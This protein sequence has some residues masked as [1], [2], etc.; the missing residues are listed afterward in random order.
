MKT[1]SSKVLAAAVRSASFELRRQTPLRVLVVAIAVGTFG[2]SGCKKSESDSGSTDSSDSTSQSSGSETAHTPTPPPTLP[3]VKPPAAVTKEPDKKPTEEQ[4]KS[5]AKSSTP[6]RQPAS[7]PAPK[8]QRFEYDHDALVE[9][10]RDAGLPIPPDLTA[11]KTDLAALIHEQVLTSCASGSAED[12]GRLGSMYLAIA[13]NREESSLAVDCYTKAKELAPK[14]HKWPYMLARLFLNRNSDVRGRLELERTI[15]LE[16]NY[17]MGYGWLGN[18]CLKQENGA[19]AKEFFTKYIDLKPEDAFGY[20]GRAAAFLNLNDLEAVK[21]DLDQAMELDPSMGWSYVLLAHY[22]EKTGEGVLA[23]QAMHKASTLPIRP[24]MLLRDPLS[25]DRW[26]SLGATETA[27]LELGRLAQMRDMPSARRLSELLLSDHSENPVLILGLSRFE[28][29][30]G[31]YED[32]LKLAMRAKE[33]DPDAPETHETIARCKLGLGETD[34]ALAAAERAVE[35]NGDADYCH[36]VKG[37]VL[38]AMGRLDDAKASFMRDRELNPGRP[39]TAQTIANIW[40]RQENYEKA[41][42]FYEKALL[43]AKVG[44]HPPKTFGPLFA[45]LGEIDLREDKLDIA[46]THFGQAIAADPGYVD[47]FMSL[48]KA[49]IEQDR[50]NEALEFCD[51]ILANRPE[52]MVYKLMRVEI[53][54]RLGKSKEALAGAAELVKFYPDSADAFLVA[55]RVLNTNK[56]FDRAEVSFKRSVDLAPGSEKARVAYVEFLLSQK[57]NKEALN[58]SEQGLEVLPKSVRLANT[59]GWFRAT[60]DDESLRDPQAAIKWGE[61]ACAGTNRKL[62]SCLDTLAC[63]YA[64]AGRYDDA[65][66]TAQ[67][68]IELAKTNPL[69][70]EELINY[71]AR[72][73]L[74]K[75]G[76]PYIESAE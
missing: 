74:F 46:I 18:L 21:A 58:A 42:E 68:A 1:I 57:K 23:R 28:L 75:S 76:K 33:L 22:L 50:G 56:M 6:S 48:A 62:A 67:E 59:A 38:L 29:F 44:N 40:F 15:E 45:G 60:I 9:K 72:L 13:T 41:R 2:L 53:L 39:Q 5:V 36:R 37:D 3:K 54:D 16:P 19:E 10:C 4:D 30:Q 20:C 71:E 26:R 55:G 47:S 25:I 14:S 27:L 65:V 35:L 8:N 69:L 34:E 52:F 51:Q 32:S 11:L 61:L 17:A 12:I 49:L 66:S 73:A 31:K 70:G 64:S 24:G 43:A 7:S 63:A